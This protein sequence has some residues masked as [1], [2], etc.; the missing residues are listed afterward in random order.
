VRSSVAADGNTYVVDRQV[1]GDV[2][3]ITVEMTRAENRRRHGDGMYV[4]TD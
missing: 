1:S 3:M 2:S 4:D